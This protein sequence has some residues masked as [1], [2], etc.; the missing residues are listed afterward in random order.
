MPPQQHLYN[1][2][3]RPADYSIFA[4]EW[5][6]TTAS[7]S[8]LAQEWT[9]PHAQR[10][11]WRPA[12]RLRLARL[13]ASRCWHGTEMRTDNRTT[14]RTRWKHNV[15][16]ACNAAHNLQEH[17]NKKKI[18]STIDCFIIWKIMFLD[19]NCFGITNAQCIWLKLHYSIFLCICC[20]T[21]VSETIR[22]PPLV[23]AQLHFKK[24]K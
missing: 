23:K 6:C 22:K 7:E 12:R 2:L 21:S 18:S 14:G 17:K 11:D 10:A 19:T 8:M 4:R 15:S 20:T 9:G 24:Q 16:A 5:T 3:A 13:R 1:G